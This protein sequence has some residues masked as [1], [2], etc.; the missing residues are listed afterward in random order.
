MRVGFF[1]SGNGRLAKAAIVQRFGIGIEPALLLLDHKANQGLE[2]FGAVHSVACERV[3]PKPREEFGDRLL[4]ACKPYKLD[5]VVMTFDW[6]VPINFLKGY[7]ERVINVHP[8]LLPA[9][10]GTNALTR[11]VA[12]G[13]RYGGATI[14]EANAEM[15]SG[16]IIAQCV[17]GLR[18]GEPESSFGAR[19]FNP[20]RLMYLQ[21]LAWYAEGRIAR[22]GLGQIHVRDAIY[23]EFPISPA[24]ERAFVD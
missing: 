8:G 1:V 16:P 14:H 20:M 22:N 23:G 2:E 4:K 18:E 3:H 10:A 9:F 19:L 12:S 13:A 15:D 11:L 24:I 6:I 7:P 17:L 21:V 5:L